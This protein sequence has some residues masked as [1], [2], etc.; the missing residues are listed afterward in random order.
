VSF[1]PDTVSSDIWKCLAAIADEL[2][3]STSF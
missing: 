2:A 3:I 1:I